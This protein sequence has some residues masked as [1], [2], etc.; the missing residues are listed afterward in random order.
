V[1]T[2]IAVVSAPFGIATGSWE[3]ERD[4]WPSALSRARAEG[5]RALELTAITED[6]LDRLLGLLTEDGLVD[7]GFDRVS[8][9]APARVTSSAAECV[10]KLRTMDF[11]LVL[12]PD[13]YGDEPTVEALGSRPVFENMDVVK[14]FGK[15]VGDLQEVFA[16]F[17]RAGFCLDVAHVWTNDPT[18]RLGHQLLDAFGDRLRQV[19]VSGIEPDGTHRPTTPEDLALFD[20][21][22]ERCRHVPQI[23]EAVLT[24]V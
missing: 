20:P 4:D 17:P 2:G 8:V 1:A 16:A 14:R 6:R 10:Q 12:H 3:D 24:V 11:E 15:D 22:L 19:H 9:H 23:L 7:D 5:W 13:V 18:L 21:L